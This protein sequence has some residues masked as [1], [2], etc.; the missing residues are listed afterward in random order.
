L[1]VLSI[2]CSGSI[3]GA[4]PEAPDADPSPWSASLPPLTDPPELRLLTA[5]E[6]AASVEDLVGVVVEPSEVPPLQTSA[7]HG[8]IASAQRVTY[9]VADRYYEFAARTAARVRET[10]CRGETCRAF[11]DDLARRAFRG[12]SGVETITALL[13]DP[14]TGES[15]E[16][17]AETALVAVLSSPRFLYRRESAVDGR[18]TDTAIA[19]RLS[20][21]VWESVPDAELMEAAR[22]G[23]LRTAE[24]RLAQLDRMLAD[25][26]A[27]R[28]T[29]GFVFEWMGVH[30]DRIASKD[31]TVLAGTSAD[32]AVGARSSLERTID[33]VLAAPNAHFVD[34]LVAP[35]T[36]VNTDVA[37][38]LDVEPPEAGEEFVLRTLDPN[39]RLGILSHPAVLAAHTK[40]SGVSPFPLGK[41]IVENLLCEVIPPPPPVPE[42][43]SEAMG[44]QT[45]REELEGLTAHGVCQECHRR[46]GP[47]G[48]A[49]LPFDPIGRHRPNDS[50]GRP[51]DTAGS[52]PR[53]DRALVF[54]NAPTLARE[55][56]SDPSVRACVARRLFRWTYGRFE[57]N[58]DEPVIADL[59]AVATRQEGSVHAVLRELVGA[60]AF[61]QVGGAR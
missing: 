56:A 24:G 46:I 44:A 60:D 58:A 35:A 34:L 11:V 51:W 22:A 10:G 28:G 5:R 30:H 59:E 7:G 12:E 3:G 14:A 31:E 26:R 21:L 43:D 1:L 38:I 29:R 53:P 2:G 8:G 23:R 48:F 61:V 32:L 13:D 6:Y 15:I 18:W 55:L 19:T 57:S 20:H 45:L 36:Y 16:D 27:R 41:F 39:R 4:A 42:V 50:A 49:F 54:E 9:D 40:E 37:V 25:E 47:A 52:I 17:R 33:E